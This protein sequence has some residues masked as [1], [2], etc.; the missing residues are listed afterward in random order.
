MAESLA[1]FLATPASVMRVRVARAHGSAP[2]EEGAEMFVTPSAQWGTIGGGQLEYMAIDQA[3]AQLRAATGAPGT[4]PDTGGQ[5]LLEDFATAEFSRKFCAQ[6]P[7]VVLDIPLGPAIGQCCGGRVVLRLEQLGPEGRDAALRREAAA[8]A[9]QP[10]LLIFGAGHVGRALADLAQHLPVTCRLIDSRAAELG[11]SA[12]AVAKRLSALPEADLRAAPPGSAF[13]MATHDHALD[14]LLAAEAL[15][16]RDAAYAGMIGSASKRA[17]F[18]GWCRRAAP[19]VPLDALTCPI[20]AAGRGDK[21][22]A[23]IAAFTLAE[24]LAALARAPAP[25]TVRLP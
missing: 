17:S 18:A 6:D 4:N 21:R 19:D 22:P 3:R 7:A 10:H 16:R 25:Q 5:N 23:V 15:R 12:A 13:V 2:R 9:T 1:D 11:Q 20:G 14:F 24:A 8:R